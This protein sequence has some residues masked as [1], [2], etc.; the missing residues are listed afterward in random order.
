MHG[1]LADASNNW[2][3]VFIVDGFRGGDAVSVG[4]DES[5][6]L[7]IV[8]VLRRGFNEL[9]VAEDL[10]AFAFAAVSP[11]GGR[12]ERAGGG[13]LVR[14][15]QVLVLPRL[16]VLAEGAD[17]LSCHFESSRWAGKARSSR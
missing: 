15:E 11:A 10:V 14:L 16:V 5:L 9:V 3:F 1:E 17:L 2:V 8:A 7:M 6:L 12:R 13:F 4:I